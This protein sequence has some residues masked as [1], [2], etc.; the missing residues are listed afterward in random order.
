MLY[1]FREETR[2]RG[3]FAYWETSL[4]WDPDSPLC[5][6]NLKAD[7][8]PDFE[9]EFPQIVLSRDSAAVDFVGGHAGFGG[10]GLLVSEK[11][12]QVLEE[13]KLPPHQHYA[14]EVLHKGKPAAK[15]YFWLQILLLDNYG[16]IDFAN[17]EFSVEKHLSD[18]REPVAIANEGELK[19]LIEAKKGDFEFHFARMALNSAYARNPF[20]LFYLEWLGGVS[21]LGPV[22]TE[23]A[24]AAF[25]REGLKGHR[26]S[27]LDNVTVMP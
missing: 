21:S 23:R 25:E 24:K 14:V 8:F 13:L 3:A 17:S 20:D 4:R 22:V 10:Q 5:A 2:G 27:A 26:L 15:R 16:W 1:R 11:A 7:A 6:W 19:R 18:T 12:L 9:P